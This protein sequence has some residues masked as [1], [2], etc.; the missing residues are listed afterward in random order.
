MFRVSSSFFR[1]TDALLVLMVMVM[2]FW[3]LWWG[4][5]KVV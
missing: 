2:V 4:S 3:G 1:S 5:E